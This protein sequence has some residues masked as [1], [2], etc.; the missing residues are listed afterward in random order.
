M[1]ERDGRTEKPTAKKRGDAKKKGQIAK[2]Q[3]LS[4][5]A[6]LLLASYLIPMVFQSVA[7]KIT[8]LFV[9]VGQINADSLTSR[10]ALGQLGKGFGDF[11]DAI[12]MFGAFAIVLV[13]VINFA[14]IGFSLNL[15]LLMPK[16]SKLKP[17]NYFKKVFSPTGMME[18]AKSVLKMIVILLVG[19]LILASRIKELAS[20]QLSLYD[21]VTMATSGAMSLLRTVALF[22]LVLGLVDFGRQKR[23]LTKQLMMSKQEIKDESRQSEGDPTVK[24][25]IRSMQLKLARRR[26]MTSVQKADVVVVNPTHYAVAISYDP[27]R[28]PAPIIVAKGA[29]FVAL[30]IKKEA[31]K[32]S[33]PV[34][35]DPIL[36]RALHR[37]CELGT[38]IPP[39]FFLAVAKLL[40]FVYSLGGSARYYETSHSTKRDDLGDIADEVLL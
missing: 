22:G 2:S 4:Q 17:N 27:K 32:W 1:S 16:F 13:L 12:G 9:S 6:L 26:M 11:A 33:I 3:E 30:A 24:G 19:Y 40:A 28:S 25:R 34:V 21:S 31:A 7:P 10:Y 15:S 39:Q 29:G 14:Q 5:W 37:S 23:M 35:R 36:A 38:Q 18:T 8:S 20:G